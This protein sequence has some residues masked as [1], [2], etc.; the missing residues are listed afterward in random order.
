[1]NRL[2]RFAAIV[3]GL[4][5][6]QS[7]YPLVVHAAAI[8]INVDANA[9]KRPINPMVYGVAFG[10]GTSLPDLNC[11]INRW[12]GNPNSTYN[13]QNDSSNRSADWYFQS[14]GNGGSNGASADNFISTSK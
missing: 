1:M 4:I 3:F 5:L 9:N 10:D 6:L 11:V 14:I 8:A 13:W 7:R 12:G 2:N